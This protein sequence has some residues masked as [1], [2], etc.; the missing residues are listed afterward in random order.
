MAS[1]NGSP[2]LKLWGEFKSKYPEAITL[3]R[4]GDH[5]ETYN[6]DARDVSKILGVSLWEADVI[7]SGFE[8]YKLQDYLPKLIRAG[9]KVAICD[10]LES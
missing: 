4:C 6:E 5:Y 10:Q 7:T 2:V 8:S 3:L 9:K 1:K